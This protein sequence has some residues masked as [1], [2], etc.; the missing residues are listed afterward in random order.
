MRPLLSAAACALALLLAACSGDD[1][2]SPDVGAPTTA[3]TA[4]D[5]P[6]PPA[7]RAG[8]CYRLRHRDA[9]A[10]V[11]DRAAVPCRRKHTSVTFHVG[12]LDL[13]PGR[14]QRP[15]RIDSPRVRSQV[16]EACLRRLREHLG[17]TEE[18]FR[19]TMLTTV[20][21][22]PNVADGERGARWFRCDVV[23]P[24]ARRSLLPLPAPPALRGILDDPDRRDAFSTCGTAE[25]GTAGFRRVTCG[26]RH[27]W[28]AVASVDLGDGAY[29][30]IRDTADRMREPCTEAARAWADDPLDFSW[31]EE[32][33]TREQWQAGRRHG[34]CWTAVTD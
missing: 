20:W 27:T 31:T 21:F 5:E 25:P 22:T 34:L 14:R 12:R 7:P 8:A 28:R 9:L 24:G 19:L 29:P 2:P 26:Q 10:S 32:R 15:L 4:S 6:R 16:A 23:A 1:G 30:E 3:P 17:G 33:P 13:R 11:S 18:S